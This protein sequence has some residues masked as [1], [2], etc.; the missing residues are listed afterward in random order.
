[1][2]GEQRITLQ[3]VT[4]AFLGDASQQGAWRTPPFKALLRQWWRVAAAPRLDYD[5]RRLREQE[6]RA[7]GHAWLKDPTGNAWALQSRLR[8]RLERW[9]KG[10]LKNWPND[11][12]VRHPEVGQGGMP[13]GAHLYLGYGPLEHGQGATRLKKP[14]AV[15]PGEQ[16]VMVLAYPEVMRE[17]I[18]DALQLIAWFGALGGR[19]R[20]GWGSLTLAGDALKDLAAVRK[21]DALL[22]RVTRPFRACLELDWPHALGS[23]EKGPLVW[24]IRRPAPSWEEV[25]TTLAEVKIAVRTGLAFQKNRDVS[26]PVL[27]DRHLLAYP[28]TNHGVLE[29]SRIDEKTRRPALTSR[30]KLNQDERLANQLR[31]KV[32]REGSAYVGL[33]FH[34]PCGLPQALVGK[35]PRPVRD[36]LLT[37]EGQAGVW[38]RVHQAL[39]GR[40]ELVRVLEARG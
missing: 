25:M 6:G 36:E 8:L 11:P 29:W 14:P 39:D 31:F 17:D 27:E 16:C 22:H 35:G 9:A 18:M 19:S 23:D 34:M 26:D 2:I 32:H 1:M 13:V 12:R 4:P 37:P 33:I 21:G 28:V 3:F 40:A 38:K 15:A 5:H 20:N 7:F 10:G 24:R 30:G